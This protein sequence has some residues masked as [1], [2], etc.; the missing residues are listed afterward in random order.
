MSVVRGDGF[1]FRHQCFGVSSGLRTMIVFVQ[2]TENLFQRSGTMPLEVA[3]RDECGRNRRLEPGTGA[4]IGNGP[5]LNPVLSFTNHFPQ[6]LQR[7]RSFRICSRFPPS[8]DFTACFDK[9][10]PILESFALLVESY[11]TTDYTITPFQLPSLLFGGSTPSL[12]KISLDNAEVPWTSTLFKNLTFLCVCQN[13][14]HA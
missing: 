10:A 12:R 13:Y 2:R 11:G 9:A 8:Q 1:A 7:M 4:F 5:L 6:T 3:I 14:N